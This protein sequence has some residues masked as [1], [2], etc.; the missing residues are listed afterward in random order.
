VTD[1]HLN[2]RIVERP[3]TQD[4]LARAARAAQTLSETLW[5]AL[6]HEELANRWEIG[7]HEPRVAELCERLGEVAATV[8]LLARVGEGASAEPA[9]LE[10]PAG[11]VTDDEQ[12]PVRDSS[13][14][15]HDELRSVRESPSVGESSLAPQP[16]AAAVLVD[17]LAPAIEIKDE[18]RER[19]LT[20]RIESI[21]RR[22]ERYEQDIARYSERSPGG[23]IAS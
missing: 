23:P 3:I 21:G 1:D 4:R 16:P 13:L 15:I 6:L 9:A 7:Q 17:E 18:R 10:S 12:P 2:P 11:R 8:G 14:P 22:L 19:D 5:E 20:A